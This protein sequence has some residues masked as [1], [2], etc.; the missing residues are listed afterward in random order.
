MNSE[1]SLGIFLDSVID[2]PEPPSLEN[3]R[4]FPKGHYSLKL[5]PSGEE[6]LLSDCVRVEISGKSDSKIVASIIELMIEESKDPYSYSDLLL[7]IQKFRELFKAPSTRLTD[8]E[9]KGIWGELWFM[10][11]AIFRCHSRQEMEQ[12]LNSWKGSEVAKRDFRFPNS[13]IIFEIKT[14]EKRSREHE[15]SSADQLTLKKGELAAF[16]VSIGVRREEAGAAHTIKSLF[17]VI[18]QKMEDEL[19][20]NKLENLL[21]ER[22]WTSESGQDISLIVST[23]V[24]LRLFPFDKV[25]TILPLPEGITDATWVVHLDVDDELSIIEQD[26]ILEASISVD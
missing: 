3:M 19:L 14:T 9:L 20:K 15:I 25:P 6:R 17:G 12:C 13:K 16:L 5:Q 10:K 26:G 22:K 2:D 8:E 7:A 24:P 21:K 1:G 18:C 23:G 11:E 4:F